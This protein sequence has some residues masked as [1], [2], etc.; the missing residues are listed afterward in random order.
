MDKVKN[1]DLLSQNDQDEYIKMKDTLSSGDFRYQHQRAN[2][3][4]KRAL[5]IIHSFCVKYNDQDSLRSMVCGICWI[6]DSNIAV[7]TTRLSTLLNKTPASINNSLQ[8]LKY[9]TNMF[10]REDAGDLLKA[11]PML[12]QNLQEKRS[13]LIRKKIPETDTQTKNENDQQ[14]IV[15]EQ[16]SN[17]ID[18]Q[19][20]DSTS[21]DT[22]YEPPDQFEP[23]FDFDPYSC[24]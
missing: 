10:K 17:H 22:W 11:L 23:E 3:V 16:K 20:S 13:W 15:I 9:K 8:Q 12:E 2:E 6:D 1:F 21:F 5:E 19:N 7:N 14:K 24:L 4:F 18:R